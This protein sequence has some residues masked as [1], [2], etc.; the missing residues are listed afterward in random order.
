MTAGKERAAELRN[1]VPKKIRMEE[2]RAEVIS[3]THLTLFQK[4]TRIPRISL[5]FTRKSLFAI[6]NQKKKKTIGT[7][8]LLLTIPP[9]KELRPLLEQLF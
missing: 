8:I 2:N 7:I 6:P 9:Q 5:D 1:M 3:K 4:R